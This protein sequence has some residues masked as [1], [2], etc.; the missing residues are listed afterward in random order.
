MDL[1]IMST[2]CRL[3]MIKKRIILKQI[4]EYEVETS[5]SLESQLCQMMFCWGTQVK[6][7]FAKADT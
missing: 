2:V 7:C 6:R 5:A 4:G 3:L 1:I